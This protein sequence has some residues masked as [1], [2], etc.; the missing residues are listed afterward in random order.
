VLFSSASFVYV[1]H[2]NRVYTS[3]PDGGVVG[4]DC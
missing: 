4:C 2:M 1:Y 3:A